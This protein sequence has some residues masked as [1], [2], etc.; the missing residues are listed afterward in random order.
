MAFMT[1]EVIFFLTKTKSIIYFSTFFFFIYLLP[2]LINERP[3]TTL[4]LF[5]EGHIENKLSAKIWLDGF[6]SVF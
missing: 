2:N 3:H 5:D 4:S 1:L 6:D